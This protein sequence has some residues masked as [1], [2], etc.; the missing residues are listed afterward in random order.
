M[1][2]PV[3]YSP[4][5]GAGSAS[6]GLWL[7]LFTSKRCVEEFQSKIV[8]MSLQAT[9][10]FEIFSHLSGELFHADYFGEYDSHIS[11]TV[12]AILSSLISDRDPGLD[13]ISLYKV[14]ATALL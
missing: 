4:C 3:G 7:H 10:V 5:F 1:K 2:K 8:M 11:T 6:G 13:E 12:A 9:P 14:I